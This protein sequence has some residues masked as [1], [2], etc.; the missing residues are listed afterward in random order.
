M[1]EQNLTQEYIEASNNYSEAIAKGDWHAA[2]Q[3]ER[4]LY[5]LDHPW[6]D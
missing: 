6:V 4:Q 5:R 1:K 2:Y 3:Y